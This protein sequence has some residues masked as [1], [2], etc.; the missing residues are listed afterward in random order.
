VNSTY[1]S[2]SS[3]VTALRPDACA[4]SAPRTRSCGRTVPLVS[5]VSASCSAKDTFAPR[6]G[7]ASGD[8]A[9]A[10]GSASRDCQM[11]T[12]MPTPAATATA[13]APMPAFPRVD[14]SIDLHL[15]TLIRWTATN[16]QGV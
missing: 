8:S 12:G 3:R 14:S 5:P 7:T 1:S 10:G 6:P 16:V 11:A 13:S 15:G 4:C 9:P 2:V